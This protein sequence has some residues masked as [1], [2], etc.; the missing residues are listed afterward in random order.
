[1][2]HRLFTALALAAAT[3]CALFAAPASQAQ[4]PPNQAVRDGSDFNPSKGLAME[5]YDPVSCF[6]NGGSK[7]KEGS[8]QRFW[9]HKGAT[10]R[11][12][13]IANRDLFRKNPARFE[14]MY[15]GWCAYM[16]SEGDKVK[17]SPPNHRIE[18]GHLYHCFK[19]WFG[20][21]RTKW[22]K[23]TG[24]VLKPKADAHWKSSGIRPRN[25]K[26][27][28]L[29]TTTR[30]GRRSSREAKRDE[31]TET[32]DSKKGQQRFAAGLFS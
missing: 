21:G 8:K 6:K 10:S 17:P 32:V 7:P 27:K 25:T 22:V 3:T 18:D 2:T 30:R 29:R 16:M 5:D 15:I 24:K 26:K 19:G 12:T 13:S 20:N 11:F 9:V 23:A 1:M 4:T 31:P 14:P 28:R